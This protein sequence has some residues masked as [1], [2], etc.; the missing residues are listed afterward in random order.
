MTVPPVA[1]YRLSPSQLSILCDSL[2]TDRSDLYVEQFVAVLDGRLDPEAARA[3][4]TAVTARHAALRTGVRWEGVDRP[5]QVVHPAVTAAI[6]VRSDLAGPEAVR[7]VA[8]AERRA[9]FDPRRAPLARLVLLALTGERWG[10]VLTYHHIILDGDSR[11]RVLRNLVDAYNGRPGEAG[12]GGGSYR[13]FVAWQYANQD[14]SLTEQWRSELSSL[15]LPTPLPFADVAR[16]RPRDPVAV[17]TGGL[18]P[19]QWAAVRRRAAE[20]GTTPYTLFEAAWG[21]TLARY[22]GQA[23]VVFGRVCSI[24]PSFL[25]GDDGPAGL[26]ANSVPVRIGVDPEE[27]SS[28][29]LRRLHRRRGALG[30][31]DRVAPATLAAAI[32][33][34]RAGEQVFTSLLAWEVS[35]ATDILAGMDGITRVEVEPSFSL[36]PYPITVMAHVSDRLDVQLVSDL[37]MEGADELLTSCLQVLSGLARPGTGR[38]RDLDVL[39]AD[40]RRTLLD[41]MSGAGR[42]RGLDRT[43][44]D[45][46]LQQAAATPGATALVTEDQ[47]LSYAELSTRAAAVAE[48]LRRRGVGVED[49]VGLSMARRADLVVA[50]LGVLLAGGCY[51]PLDPG[52]PPS[53]LRDA[54]DDAQLRLFIADG[55]AGTTGADGIPV[56]SVEALA[57]DAGDAPVTPGR[58][59]AS[60]A[61]YLLYTSGSTGRPKGVV[62]EHRACASFLAWARSEL[63]SRD[64]VLA[65]TSI[66]FDLSVFEIFGTLTTGGCVVLVDNALQIGRAHAADVTV[67][68]TVPSALDAL[69]RERLIPSTVRTIYVA[70]EPLS[71]LVADQT[72]AASAARLVN[73]YGPTEATTYAT[74]SEVRRDTTAAPDIGTPISSTTVYVL[75]D[76]LQ[77]V[78]PGVA[79]ELFLGGHGVARG[80]WRC[81]RLT[82]ERFV[83]NP[84]GPS[85]SRLYRTGDLAVMRPSGV[86]EYLG[87]NDRQVKINGYRI[88]PGEIEERAS[89][90]PGVR[91]AVVA[92]RRDR[93]GD[94][95]LSLYVVPTAGRPDPDPAA[96]R[97]ML[98]SVLPRHMVP[99][100]VVPIRELPLT[101][102]GKIDFAALPDPGPVA[103]TGPRPRERSEI[104]DG[105][106]AAWSEVIGRAVGPDENFFE[107]GGTSLK[108][109]PLL[110]RLQQRYPEANLQL[111]DLFAHPSIR[112]LSARISDAGAVGEAAEAGVGAGARR[113]ALR[114]LRT[115]REEARRG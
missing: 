76:D 98:A 3:A 105:V 89:R 88:E 91:S 26:F 107:A 30:D 114:D 37:G 6:D 44:G 60:A 2:R 10:M 39:S 55:A 17:T 9:G 104:D 97:Q 82:A 1:A 99:A 77:P 18:G 27:E 58:A 69:A 94:R 14:V 40:Q 64:R 90:L 79:G 48:A 25:G 53:W 41:E 46:F 72:F 54:A 51:V 62:V 49:R 109:F 80:Y 29:L 20:A 50:M 75:D 83:P 38:L 74:A 85:G 67:L 71:R 103:A 7:A 84:F 4:W 63:T 52:Y 111:V 92:V 35:G 115:R 12:T 108:S 102:N 101:P 43:V 23:E 21:V 65:V 47:E 8:D 93:A 33:G 28:E 68:N 16:D 57:A 11:D 5:L 32:P 87:R 81:P 19:E 42:L 95:L 59:S 15:D 86:V 45:L 24:R 96:V 31:A 113:S 110:I 112:R 13:D 66:S 22:T 73:L 100:S 36:T 78:P 70:G 34:L 106:A 61:A 56:V